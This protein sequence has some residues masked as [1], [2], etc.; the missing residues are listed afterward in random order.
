MLVSTAFCSFAQAQAP[1][2][3]GKVTNGHGPDA[4]AFTFVRV[5]WQG[6]R[7]GFGLGFAGGRV[8]LWAHDYPTAEQNFYVAL[9]AL[10]SL[11]ITFENKIL[12]LRE[13]AIFDFPLLY[14]CEVGYWAP[15]EEETKMLGE[16]L[17]RGGFLIVDDFRSDF[18]WSNFVRHMQR[19]V[20]EAPQLLDLDHPVF[21]CFFEFSELARHSPYGG[22]TPHYYAIFNADGRMMALINYNNDI[23]DGWE[24]PESDRE[25]STEAFKLGINYLIYAMTH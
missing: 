8:P 17:N 5:E 16:Y 2:A 4:M 13:Q 20:P 1:A 18:E 25:F 9:D 15:D 11:P 23:G 24:W 3:N 7:T 19:I 14:I 21:H 6:G 22:L 10:T 12:T